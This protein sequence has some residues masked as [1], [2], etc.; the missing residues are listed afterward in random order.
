VVV[1]QW[2]QAPL[3]E[4]GAGMGYVE[5]DQISNVE[6]NGG[7]NTEPSVLIIEAQ[8]L[9]TLDSHCRGR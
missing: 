4:S 5:A 2:N 1:N 9:Q 7:R 8:D 6:V 3:V